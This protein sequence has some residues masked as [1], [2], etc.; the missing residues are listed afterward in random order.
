VC[1]DSVKI[2]WGW[3]ATP[4]WKTDAG[5][6]VRDLGSY[7]S[8]AVCLDHGNYRNLWLAKGC[9]VHDGTCPVPPKR[10]RR[11]LHLFDDG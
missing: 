1:K 10:D 5:F 11:E 9:I 8:I 2:S 7:M 6:F 3:K 4:G